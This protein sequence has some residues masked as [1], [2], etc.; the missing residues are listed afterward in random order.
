MGSQE[1]NE[2]D[3]RTQEKKH[4]LLRKGEGIWCAQ[5]G[6]G[7]A[8]RGYDSTFQIPKAVIWKDKFVL[9]YPK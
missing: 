4:T 2:D 3:Q 9:N 8:E 1:S 5:P 7:K 6:K